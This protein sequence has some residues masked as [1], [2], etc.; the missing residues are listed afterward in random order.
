VFD[1]EQTGALRGRVDDGVTEACPGSCVYHVEKASAAYLGRADLL[2]ED[3]KIV[4]DVYAHVEHAN[5][6][7]VGV[8]DRLV[9]G[10]VAAA[11]Q[12][13]RSAVGTTLEQ[14]A[15]AG[16]LVIEL[17]AHRAS[18]ALGLVRGTDADEFAFAASEH[19]CIGA[20]AR[21]EG[22]HALEVEVDGLS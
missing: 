3:V 5:H 22:V 10:H 18:A 11:K 7:A 13:S 12:L 2:F 16:V 4:V 14:H 19:G 21:C 8:S 6:L 17:G 9:T 15:V 1:A 20:G